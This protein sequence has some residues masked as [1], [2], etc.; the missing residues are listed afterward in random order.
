MAESFWRAVSEQKYLKESGE[1][2]RR[3]RENE[4]DQ[5]RAD[6]RQREA[7]GEDYPSKGRC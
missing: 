6:R 2:D 4:E 7:M 3:K 1:Y 5:R